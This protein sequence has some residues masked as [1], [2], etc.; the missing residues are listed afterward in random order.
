MNKPLTTKRECRPRELISWEWRH[1]IATGAVLLRA[2]SLHL[3]TGA[4][5]RSSGMQSPSLSGYDPDHPVSD[6]DLRSCGASFS[7][8]V[9]YIL[10]E[11]IPVHVPQRRHEAARRDALKRANELLGEARWNRAVGRPDA[12]STWYIAKRDFALDRPETD[13]RKRRRKLPRGDNLLRKYE[14]LRLDLRRLLPRRGPD[15]PISA[16]SLKA[17]K[18]NYPELG[19]CRTGDSARVTPSEAARI[20]LARRYGVQPGRVKR[21]L[22]QAR[23]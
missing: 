1:P 19:W 16:S 10:D 9:G 2:A 4:A 23:R 20:V 5:A 11:L 18:Q 13:L 3:P 17:I 6:E 22:E 7:L 8:F 14:E 15:E 21:A 12:V